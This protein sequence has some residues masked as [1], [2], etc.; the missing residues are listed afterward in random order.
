MS[1]LSRECRAFLLS[2]GCPGRTDSRAALVA[3]SL[4]LER[5]RRRLRLERLRRRRRRLENLSR[6][7]RPGCHSQRRIWLIGEWRVRPPR[8]HQPV[9]PPQLVQQARPARQVQPARATQPAWPARWSR[10]RVQAGAAVELPQMPLDLPRAPAE[11]QRRGMRCRPAQGAPQGGRLRR[12]RIPPCP[13]ARNPT[14]RP[15]LLP[16]R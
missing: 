2:R 7:G 13:P 16:H 11:L 10:R 12:D 5:L 1:L 14:W 3:R 4:T 8:P 9:R 6:G 15:G